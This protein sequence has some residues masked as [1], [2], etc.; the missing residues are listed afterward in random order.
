ME[1]SV[2]RDTKGMTC[3]LELR[4]VEGSTS[5]G[6]PPKD[7]QQPSILMVHPRPSQILQLSSQGSC[8]CPLLVSQ[9]AVTSHEEA[10][11]ELLPPSCSDQCLII[12]PAFEGLTLR[13]LRFPLP[14]E[15]CKG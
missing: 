10:K 3:G 15:C 12:V 1:G 9:D 14:Q 4:R 2:E 8:A 11:A 6:Q 5:A 13:F 7:Q